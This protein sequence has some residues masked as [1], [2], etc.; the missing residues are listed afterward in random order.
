VILKAEAAAVQWLHLQL[1]QRL[2]LQQLV[3]T[4]CQQCWGCCLRCLVQGKLPLLLQLL[5]LLHRVSCVAVGLQQR[6]K[7]RLLLQLLVRHL[8][9]RVQIRQKCGIQ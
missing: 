8:L 6:V 3:Q 2:L 4:R 5:L 7:H 9:L 1:Q